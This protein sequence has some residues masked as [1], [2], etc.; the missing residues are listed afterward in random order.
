MRFAARESAILARFEP[1]SGLVPGG[2]AAAPHPPDGPCPSARGHVE[3]GGH[4]AEL[5]E[6]YGS[7]NGALPAAEL[8]DFVS[9]LARR[10]A[11]FPT[12]GHVAVK[13][14]VNAIALAPADDLRRDSDLLGGGVADPETQS[15]IAAADEARP[16]DSGRGEGSRAA[17]GLTSQPPSQG[18]T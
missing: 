3:R 15:R 10:I 14:R 9:A 5:A 2:G 12:A 1:A 4:D 13:D 6:R 18:A 17:A 16:A 7:I 11:G 8:G